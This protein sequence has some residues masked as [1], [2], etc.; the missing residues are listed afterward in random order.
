MLSDVG[1]NE[2]GIGSGNVTVDGTTQPG[3][4]DAAGTDHGVCGEGYRADGILNRFEQNTVVGAALGILTAGPTNEYR[5]NVLLNNLTSIGFTQELAALENYNPARVTAITDTQVSGTNG[6]ILI[7]PEGEIFD[8]TCPYCIIELYADPLD[9]P[10][11]ERAD[12]TES[13]AI[14]TADGEG[15]W[16][17][18]LSRPLA[19]G[20]GIRTTSTMDSYEGIRGLLFERGFTTRL[21][22]QA[23]TPDNLAGPTYAVRVPRDGLPRTT[24]TDGQG[25]VDVSAPAGAFI[26]PTQLFY[27]TV[28]S[29]IITGL[30]DGVVPLKAVELVGRFATDGS[31]IERSQA[32]ITMRIPYSEDELAQAGVNETDLQVLLLE[33]SFAPSLVAPELAG[34]GGFLSQ[35]GTDST[36]LS[37]PDCD[38]CSVQ[39]L[40][41][42]NVV[43]VSTNSYGV[44]AVAGGTPA[45]GGDNRLY[46]PLVV[47]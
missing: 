37:L 39:V 15:N 3:G 17:A 38:G 25:T 10:D 14:T 12:T 26:N 44:L 30:G 42:E 27:S 4:R 5:S 13:L 40:P 21:S 47:R 16:T 23:Y 2:L 35:I 28:P 18:T 41:D 32:P 46:L 8:P 43:E 33:D 34:V 45:V 31:R 20:E 11:E 7:T 36:W 29:N 22:T 9:A 19:D 6:D 1:S 24:L